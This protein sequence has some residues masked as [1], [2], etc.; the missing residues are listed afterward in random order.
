MADGR[1]RLSGSQ[2]RKRK[3]EKEEDK[4]R[5]AGSLKQFFVSPRP[6]NNNEPQPGSSQDRDP[7]DVHDTLE[8]LELNHS[9]MS[10]LTPLTPPTAQT[11]DTESGEA[12]KDLKDFEK[13]NEFFGFLSN[14]SAFS[15]N[16]ILEYCKNLEMKLTDPTTENMDIN[17]IDLYN[18]IDTLSIYIN[19]K[20]SMSAKEVLTYLVKNDLQCIFPNL[21]VALR[22]FLTMP[23]TV[24]HGERSFSKL[25]LIKT[26]LRSTMSQLRLS[27]LAIISIEKDIC[28]NL[29]V[30]DLIREFSVKKARK[31][32]F[33]I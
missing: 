31:V 8:E 17:A 27:N 4:K 1:K 32:D 9:T 18:E 10:T 20:N 26:Y 14:L 29:D 19:N 22:I 25:K 33:N 2:Y 5:L 24:A 7:D 3:L 15:K 12:I 13:H 28:S 16:Q 6:R 30:T 23:V 11:A 21:F